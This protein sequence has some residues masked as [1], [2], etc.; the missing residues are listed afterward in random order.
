MCQRI[1]LYYYLCI[2]LFIYLF[3][4]FL[5]WYCPSV[6]VYNIVKFIFYFILILLNLFILII[7]FF[8]I[9]FDLVCLIILAVRIIMGQKGKVISLIVY[10]F[11]L[12]G[13]FF[14]NIY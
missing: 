8:V 5:Q 3:V 4:L 1:E 7:V 13:I 6:N 12:K 9:V 10:N 11:L 14:I 2:Y